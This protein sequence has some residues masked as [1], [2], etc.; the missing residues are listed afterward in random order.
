MFNENHD[1][2][3]SYLS[4]KIHHQAL[5]DEWTSKGP[6]VEDMNSKGSE[7]CSLIT[8]LT[9]PAKSKTSSKSGKH[10]HA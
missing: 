8:F 1:L 5:L 2:Y 9:S 10:Q 7:L 6:A 3:I 4:D